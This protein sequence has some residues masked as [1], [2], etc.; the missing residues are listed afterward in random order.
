VKKAPLVPLLLVLT[1]TVALPSQSQTIGPAGTTYNLGY[2]SYGP[3]ARNSTLDIN[4]DNFQSVC[5]ET[6]FSRAKDRGQTSEYCGWGNVQST[7]LDAATWSFSYYPV[8][9]VNGWYINFSCSGRFQ[10]TCG[11]D[12]G[13][14]SGSGNPDEQS[15]GE[16]CSPV[17]ID[18]DGKG[19]DF[20]DRAGGVLFDIDAD[21]VAERISWTAADSNDAFVVLDRNGNGGIDDGS[22]LFGDVTLQPAGS[23]PNGYDALAVYDT[24][25]DGVIDGSDSVYAQLRL[26]VDHSHDGIAQ[27]HELQSL[28]A[29]GVT[30]IS[31][32]QRESRRHDR[33]G[34]LLRYKSRVDLAGSD[35]FVW[36]VDVF[37][38]AP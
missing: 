8:R 7:S 28:A 29:G 16:G 6:L 34:N 5:R 19:F 21:G 22:E 1:F 2:L 9:T 10:V 3:V 25:R 35:T 14:G 27:P 26:W 24:N 4:H 17:V 12:D 37:F 38:I 18:M 20:T 15:C 23:D 13:S 33:Y 32:Q 31:V 30:A 11:P 36:S